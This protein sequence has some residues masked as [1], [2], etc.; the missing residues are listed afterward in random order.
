MVVIEMCKEYGV[1]AVAGSCGILSIALAARE[2]VLHAARLLSLLPCG[3]SPAP[4]EGIAMASLH[5]TV[6]GKEES[7]HELAKAI[8]IGRVAECDLLVDDREISR[9]HCR[10]EPTPEGW[11][12][13]DLGSKNG[14]LVSG[15]RVERHLLVSGDVVRVGNTTLTFSADQPA[16]RP[17]SNFPFG[18]DELLAALSEVAPSPGEF[19]SGDTRRLADQPN[20]HVSQ[21][22]RELAPD[23]SDYMEEPATGSDASQSMASSLAASLPAA[24]APRYR[25]PASWG[26]PL[27]PADPKAAA[28]MPPSSRTASTRKKQTRKKT[29]APRQP[30]EFL[31][32]LKRLFA[33][34]A[35]EETGGPWYR[36]KIPKPVFAAV[37]GALAI[38]VVWGFYTTLFSGPPRSA[39]AH[40]APTPPRPAAQ[41]S[42]N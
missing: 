32:P 16:S 13:T 35:T 9:R 23:P 17:A 27:A 31:A 3:N 25:G 5:V 4:R 41:V 20:P 36:R 39:S 1:K 10:V 38:W 2:S 37:I 19:E 12:L 8:V 29:G 42:N 24:D 34:D 21:M 7:A 14:T 22:L 40:P 30:R 15:V 18:E 26:A 11:I 33:D 28:G 6:G